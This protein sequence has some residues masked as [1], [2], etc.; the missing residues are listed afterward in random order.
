MDPFS[1]GAKSFLPPGATPQHRV[2]LSTPIG[3]RIF[4]AGE[5]TSI[6]FAGTVLG[7]E[8]SGARAA[9]EVLGVVSSGEKIAVI[10][11][12]AAGAAAARTLVKR[13]FDVI[14]LEARDRVGGRI[15]TRSPKSWPLTVELGAWRLGAT[16]DE[17]LLG[18]LADL[19]ISSSSLTG[20]LAA[21]AGGNT[22]TNP[23]GT[24]AL[25]TATTWATAQ[26]VDPRLS[27]ALNDSNANATAAAASVNGLAG[28]A[29]LDASLAT[30]VL[31]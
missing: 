21:G 2:D 17:A 3:G 8:Q 14:L 27:T 30:P 29:L 5:A 16:A 1:R 9:A 15:H 26:S 23:V 4:F 19:G 22:S 18:R 24:A 6:D 31:V 10:G 11:A 7:A 25:T 12:G 13:G 20:L 28:S